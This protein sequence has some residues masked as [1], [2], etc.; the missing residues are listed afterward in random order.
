MD[1]SLRSLPNIG[2]VM[3]GKLNK[4]GIK[5]RGA[6]LRRD[7]YKVFDELLKKVD[8]TLCRCALAAIV[9]AKEGVPWHAVTKHTAAEYQKRHKRH[10]WGRC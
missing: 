3:E 4:I 10:K 2:K 5:S 6:F 7:P 8:P 9:G 1:D